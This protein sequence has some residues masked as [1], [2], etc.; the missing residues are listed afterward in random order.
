[1]IRTEQ[2]EFF[3]E[4]LD[5]G[6]GVV[7]KE[8]EEAGGGRVHIVYRS[9][10]VKKPPISSAAEGFHARGWCAFPVLQL[11]TSF[12]EAFFFFIHPSRRHFDA[13]DLC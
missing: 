10:A 6:D 5:R 2:E 7:E 8:E 11:D 4:P 12:F 3:I 9:S 1:M 13:L